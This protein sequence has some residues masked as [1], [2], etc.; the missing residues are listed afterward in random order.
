MPHVLRLSLALCLLVGAAG[1][2][3]GFTDRDSQ[4]TLTGKAVVMEAMFPDRS[5]KR[6]LVVHTD[7][8]SVV[9][10]QSSKLHSLLA[11]IR[12]GQRV[13]ISGRWSPAAAAAADSDSSGARPAAAG[14]TVQAGFQAQ[15]LE[16]L[17]SGPAI[18]KPT[19]AYAAAPGGGSGGVV[20]AAAGGDRIVLTSNKLASTSKDIRTLV[21]PIVG[22]TPRGGACPGTTLPAT[23]ADDVRSVVLPE[24]NPKGVTL[25]STYRDC[26]YGQSL[27][28][29]R[30][31]MV[32]EIVELPCQGSTAGFNWSMSTCEGN[33][34]DGIGSA[35]E[36]VLIARGINV[37]QYPHRLYLMPPGPCKFLGQANIGCDYSS[38]LGCRGWIGSG[39][40]KSAP[41]M[42]HELGH[43]LSLD[44]AGMMQEGAFN[45]YADL[46][47]S[48]GF[49]CTQRCFNTPHA[50]QLGWIS[51][52]QFDN[53]SLALGQ[54]VTASLAS[55]SRAAR[56]GVRIVPTWA[57]TVYP[58]YVG[59]RTREGGDM[60]LDAGFVG[61]LTVHSA[62]ITGPQ[63]AKK[64][65]LLTTLKPGDSWSHA[66]TGLVLRFLLLTPSKDA[67]LQVCRKGGPETLTTCLK[68]QDND[69]NGLAGALDPACLPL[70]R[71][72]IPRRPKAL[73]KR[74]R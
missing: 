27:V 6:M 14:E 74:Q 43:T 5:H 56:S 38:P 13:R 46:S 17:D 63:D 45:E 42:V 47:C 72:N 67:T 65:L 7:G 30:N 39:Y 25:G 55:Q 1:R 22:K 40:W 10:I 71:N 28:N 4:E 70:L 33:D 54:T 66:A 3:A 19:L 12:T 51:L 53:D 73:L 48:M 35:A 20:S 37:S 24:R 11:G 2:A 16:A 61:R 58:L 57:P 50:W 69:C 29:A 59:L 15:R 64:T 41:A 52:Q 68:G 23:T 49:C 62:N 8:G 34:M 36:A 32:P 31:S 9:Q 44:H 21:I 60:G 18:S 26:S